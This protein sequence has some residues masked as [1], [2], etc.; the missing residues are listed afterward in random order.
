MYDPPPLPPYPPH[1]PLAALL[2]A[3]AG[4]ALC[5]VALIVGWRAGRK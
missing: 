4:V 1:S 3:A 2:L 5:I